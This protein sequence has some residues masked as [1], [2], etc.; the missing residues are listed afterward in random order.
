LHTFPNQR[1]AIY[2]A[3]LGDELIGAAS[4]QLETPSIVHAETLK[5][6]KK[7]AASGRKWVVAVD[8]LG[9]AAVGVVPDANDPEHAEIM[10][11]VLWGGF[12]AGAA[13]MEWYFGY[14][15]AND[16]LDCEDW[17]SRERM[18][19]LSAIAAQ[20]MR[21]HVP[22]PLV[23]NY[24]SLTSTTS[25][26]VLGKP[27]SVYVIYLPAGVATD[28]ALPAGE[29]YAVNWF[30]PRRGGSLVAGT[31]TSVTGGSAVALGRPSGTTG[32]DWVALLRRSAEAPAG[33]APKP[34]PEPETGM[35][36]SKLTLIDATRQLALGALS[37]ATIVNLAATS[38]INVLAETS[39]KVGSVLFYVDGKLV[40]REN[41][42]PYALAGDDSGV[43]RKWQPTVGTHTVRAVPYSGSNGS[44]AVGTPVEVTFSVVASTDVVTAPVEDVVKAPAAELAVT[45]FV[46]IDAATQRD[47]RELTDGAVIRLSQDGTALNIRAEVAG[48]AG[49]VLFVWDGKNYCTENLAPYAIGLDDNGV[50]RRWTPPL[51]SHTLRGVPYSGSNRS[52]NAGTARTIRIDVVN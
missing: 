32:G 47:L 13:G 45:R 6:V 20:F 16:D 40:Q 27:G 49:C 41:L 3:E 50:Y 44:G 21:D 35:A 31:V 37:N 10:K 52:G 46:L 9:K 33:E 8:E 39:G 1:D 5:W 18:W 48:S 14:D 30:D 38:A 22:L 23:A 7:S 24:N 25:D 12:L 42:A 43:F 17:T 29:T 36:V 26:Y 28:I 51:G 11:R 2:T 4:L 19:E 15:Y 34:A